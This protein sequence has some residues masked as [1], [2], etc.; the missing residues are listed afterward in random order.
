MIDFAGENLKG[1]PPAEIKATVAAD[2][3]KVRN[4]VSHPNP[5]I[6]GIAR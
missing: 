3:G 1:I 5:E 2:K 6:G 4:V